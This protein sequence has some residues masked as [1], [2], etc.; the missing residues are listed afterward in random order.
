MAGDL[1]QTVRNQS[2]RGDAPWKKINEGKLDFTGRVKYIEKNYRNSPEISGFLNRML[3]YMNGFLSRFKMINIDE[4]K[5]DLFEK[6]MSENVA[7]KI[8]TGVKRVDIQAETVKAI[9]EITEKYHIGYS[10]IAVLYPVK[11]NKALNYHIQYWIRKAFEY[12]NIPYSFISTTNDGQRATYSNSKG[13][14]VS[15]IDSSL[16]L[17][18]RAVVLTGLYPY[19]YVFDENGYRHRLSKWEAVKDLEADAKEAAQ[20]QMRKLYTACSR[21]REVLYVLSDAETGTIIDDIIRN[22]E[23]K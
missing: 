1:N 7:L 17:D 6:G 16:G 21:A 14:V 4:F 15:S 2:R 9:K 12:N 11:D 20:M 13:V 8:K 22:G 18:F 3:V 10:E 5:Y 23:K 19:T